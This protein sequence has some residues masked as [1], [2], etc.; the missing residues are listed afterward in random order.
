VLGL[1]HGRKRGGKGRKEREDERE[2]AKTSVIILMR[3]CTALC[4]Q[5]SKT[6]LLRKKRTPAHKMVKKT[7]PKTFGKIPGKKTIRK[8]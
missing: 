5:H 3:A 1:W 8:I 4:N 6:Q 2:K 7:A